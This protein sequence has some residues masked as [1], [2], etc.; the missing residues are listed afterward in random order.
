MRQSGRRRQARGRAL[1]LGREGQEEL[2]HMT[3]LE[4]LE[5]LGETKGRVR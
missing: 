3:D 1:R 5:G 2:R 4:G